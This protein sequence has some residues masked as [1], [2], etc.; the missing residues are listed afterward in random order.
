MLPV[1][2]AVGS[3]VRVGSPVGAGCPVGVGAVV[4]RPLGSGVG[5]VSVPHRAPSARQ[6]VGSPVPLATKP[7]VTDSPAASPSVSQAADRTVTCRPSTVD[8]AF[9]SDPSSVPAG[10]SN[11]SFQ[12]RFR[13]P[14]VLVT[15]Y[16]AL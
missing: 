4:G 5:A 1:G 8:R 11:S 6:P 7:T 10:R 12:S 2:A 16:W 3:P 13:S 15:T 14:P 9:H